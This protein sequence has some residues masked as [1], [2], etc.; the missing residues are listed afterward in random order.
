MNYKQFE[1][2]DINLNPTKWSEQSGIRPCL[3]L[4]TNAVSDIWKTTIIAIFTSKK[5]ERIYPYE[6]LVSKSEQNWLDLDSKLKLDQV[7]VVDKTRI[8]MKRW[9]ISDVQTQEKILK[10]LDIIFDMKGNFR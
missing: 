2:Y 6:V 4:Q 9:E 3:I 5:L 10:A 8:L 7:R 1:I